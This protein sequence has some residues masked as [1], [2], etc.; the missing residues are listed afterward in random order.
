[1]KFLITI[2]NKENESRKV[3]EIGCRIA[4]GFVADLTICYVGKK[5][6]AIIE[7][8]VNLARK[9]MAEWNIYHPGLDVLEWAFNILK[10]KGF[11]GDVEFNV[12]HYRVNTVPRVILRERLLTT[13]SHERRDHSEKAEVEMFN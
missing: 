6:K 1:M 2:K 13:P 9:S 8:D 3:L 5:S 11:A 7:G 4:Q 10:G 12:K